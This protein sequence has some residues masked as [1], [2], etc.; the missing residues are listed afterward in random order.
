MQMSLQLQPVKSPKSKRKRKRR[1][2]ANMPNLHL[3]AVVPSHPTVSKKKQRLFARLQRP[4]A[5][6]RNVKGL[7][8]LSV[9]LKKLLQLNSSDKSK[10][11]NSSALPRSLELR[12]KSANAIDLLRSLELQLRPTPKDKGKK[13]RNAL[14]QSLKA[15]RKSTSAL[16]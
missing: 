6:A 3:Q 10:K 15:K 1:Q 13:R 14:L 16:D 2:S 9:C 12:R 7:M 5:S 4:N 11:L 8:K